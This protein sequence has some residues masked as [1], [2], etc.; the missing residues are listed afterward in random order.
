MRL[1]DENRRA[2]QRYVLRRFSDP[3]GSEDVVIETFAVA[4]RKRNELPPRE[5]ESPW[6]Y[7]IAFRVISNHRRSR[8]RQNRLHLRLSRERE[9]ANDEGETPRAESSTLLL[10]M[11]ALGESDRELLRLVYWERFKY[12]DVAVALGI[13]ENAVAIRLTRAKKCLR[14][15]LVNTDPT[16]D[17]EEE[18]VEA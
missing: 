7:G 18:G 14:A 4:W 10:A 17:E 13:S 8:D 11:S 3:E 1:V 12:R 5:R 2:V 9:A 15:L 16:K 6:L